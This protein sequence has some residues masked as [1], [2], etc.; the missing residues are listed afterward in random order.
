MAQPLTN[1]SAH[2]AQTNGV[3]PTS[4]DQAT[5]DRKSA[6]VNVAIAWQLL[7]NLGEEFNANSLKGMGEEIFG[8]ELFGEALTEAVEMAD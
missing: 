6:A 1:G 7:T 5:T 8:E 4:N 2:A 3:S